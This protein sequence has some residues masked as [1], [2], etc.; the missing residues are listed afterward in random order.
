MSTLL[1]INVKNMESSTESLFFFQQPSIFNGGGQIYS[2]SLFAQNL[3]SYSQ[4]G[5]ILTFQVNLQYY[6]AI[7]EAQSLPHVGQQSGYSSVWRAIDLA[8]ATGTANDSVKASVNPVG[9]S[10]PSPGQGIQPG[11]FRVTMPS[12]SPPAVYNV[13][14]AV[15]ANGGI[16]LSN[17]VAANPN[18]NIDCKPILKFYV[19]RGNYVPGTV[20]N[21]AQSSPNSAICDFTGGHSAIDVMLNANGTW[22][23]QIVR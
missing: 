11:A 14:S 17:F 15:Q 21:F 18:I 8:P 4:T 10:Q 23:T 3:S 12:F 6:A 1:T 7:Q 22:T 9:L 19:Q 5:A 16:V 13:G 2:N 20:I